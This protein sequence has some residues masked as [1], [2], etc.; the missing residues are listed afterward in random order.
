MI[1]C[2]QN[3]DISA[4]ASYTSKSTANNFKA[5]N[6]G[7]NIDMASLPNWSHSFV[8]ENVLYTRNFLASNTEVLKDDGS[9]DLS[10]STPLMIPQD[11]S[12]ALANASPTST[13]SGTPAA[14]TTPVSS[15]APASSGTAGSSSS[16]ANSL[17][18]PKAIIG[19]FVVF[20]TFVL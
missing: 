10:G 8:A 18:S 1:A 11:I 6:W 17:A 14:T 3:S 20:V 15:F 7:A 12:A 9:I 2:L 16:G 5:G 4:Y 13:T 19:L